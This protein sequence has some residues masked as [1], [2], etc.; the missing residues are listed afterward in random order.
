MAVVAAQ[1]PTLLDLMKVH[2]PDGRI[3]EIIEVLTQR[4]VLLEDMVFREGNLETGHVVTTRTALPG[5]TYRRFN[6]GVLP[7]KARN[8]Q[9]IE[10]I[11]M[12]AAMSK[13]DCSL[14]KLYG[15]AAQY[16]ATEDDAFLQSFANEFETGM[17]YNSTLSSPQKWM[18]LAPRFADT[19]KPGG[20]QIIKMDAA[21]AGNDQA[22]AW[23]IA[24]G[25]QSVYGIY[26]KH[27]MGGMVPFDGGRQLTRDANNAEFWAFVTSWEWQVGL[28]VADWRYLCRVANIDTG[29]LLATGTALIDAMIKA[30]HKIFKAGAKLNWYFNRDIGTFLHLQAKNAVA[31]AT[32][33]I[34][35]VGGQFITRLLQTPCKESDALLS[36]ESPIP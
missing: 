25:L 5:I 33:S 21:A 13:V 3:S 19:T 28:C 17:F 24:H 9:V 2:D 27:S 4:N 29:N 32:L 34:D 35:N 12:M 8:D 20:S 22:S 1:F 7:G 10:S 18:G 23:L 14:A 26:P 36:T 31:N 6:E 30:H 11:G 16:R 15:D